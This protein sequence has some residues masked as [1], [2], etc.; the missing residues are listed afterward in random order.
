M[1]VYVPE[2]LGSAFVAGEER[3]TVPPDAVHHSHLL[4]AFTALMQQQLC[5]LCNQLCDQG[6]YVEDNGAQ[7]SHFAG[8]TGGILILGF[9]AFRTIR[10]G[11]CWV[12]NCMANGC[13]SQVHMPILL[14][15]GWNLVTRLCLIEGR[16]Y[17]SQ[18]LKR[19]RN[20]YFFLTGQQT[21]FCSVYS[22]HG[23]PEDSLHERQNKLTSSI[24]DNWVST[25]QRLLG[26]SLCYKANLERQ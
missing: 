18:F 20:A 14:A 9:A 4:L 17:L 5:C 26:P 13:Q 23:I 12:A 11:F 19:E 6:E 21:S 10:N 16:N 8:V 25:K 22:T 7:F 24:F 3:S 1:H 2:P 15:L